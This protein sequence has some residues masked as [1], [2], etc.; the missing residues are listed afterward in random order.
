MKKRLT[1]TTVLAMIIVL[2]APVVAARADVLLEPY[3]DD[4]YYRNSSNCVQ[5]MQSFYTNGE[6]GYVFLCSEPGEGNEKYSIINGETL[7]IQYTYNHNGEIWGVTET[8]LQNKKITGWIAMR[9][10]YIIYD[11]SSPNLFPAKQPPGIE[12]VNSDGN[13]ASPVQPVEKRMWDNLFL[14]ILSIILVTTVAVLTVVLIRVF[15]KKS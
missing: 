3:D 11:D 10:L 7:F 14:P 2:T 15:W 5:M 1:I 12:S 8:F 6:N 9:Q 4:F 13:P